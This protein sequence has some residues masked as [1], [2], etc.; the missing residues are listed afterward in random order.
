MIPTVTPQYLWLI[1]F[2]FDSFVDFC[3]VSSDISWEGVNPRSSETQASR[4]ATFYRATTVCL[5]PSSTYKHRV[6]AKPVP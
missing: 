3:A 6:V 4:V 5:W 1:L 2:P